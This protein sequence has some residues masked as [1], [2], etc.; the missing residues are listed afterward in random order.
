MVTLPHLR[1]YSKVSLEIGAAAEK[2]CL[3]WS[4]PRASRTFL[5]ITF[6]PTVYMK[7]SFLFV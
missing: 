1:K 6:C 7:P 3:H 5:Y 4:N 2:K